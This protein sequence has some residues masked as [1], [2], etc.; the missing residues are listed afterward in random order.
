MFTFPVM[1]YR[2]NL[3]ARAAIASDWTPL[4]TNTVTDD[5]GAVKVTY[6]DNAFGAQLP[7]L[8]S[9]VLTRNLTNGKQYTIVVEQKIEGAASIDNGFDYGS[10]D[11]T[12]LTNESSTTFIQ[13]SFVTTTVDDA[14][15][16]KLFFYGM[17][18]G[19]NIWIK[20]LSVTE[21]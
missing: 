12:A 20:L 21:N 4:G 18:S 9:T 3:V 11:Q 10:G 13:R 14:T 17:A 6:V 15:Q 16:A 8:G 2:T 19:R 7:L 5:S 1:H